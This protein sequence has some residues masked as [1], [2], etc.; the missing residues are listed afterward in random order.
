MSSFLR[1]LYHHTASVVEKNPTN[2][3]RKRDA[4]TG[5]CI[6][7][8]IYIYSWVSIQYGL[9]SNIYIYNV[10]ILLINPHLGSWWITSNSPPVWS[11]WTTSPAHQHIQPDPGGHSHV[12]PW[13]VPAVPALTASFSRREPINNQNCLWDVQASEVWSPCNGTW[14]RSLHQYHWFLVIPNVVR[15]TFPL[16]PAV[17]FG[18]LREGNIASVLRYY[19]HFALRMQEKKIMQCRVSLPEEQRRNLS[20]VD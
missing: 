7:K 12:T 8:R 3:C 15:I 9:I 10:Y 16:Q 20:C 11:T 4:A 17:R 6:L 1:W 19:S 5:W 2:T 14:T 13:Q 18:S